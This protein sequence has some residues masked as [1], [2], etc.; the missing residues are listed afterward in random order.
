MNVRRGFHKAAL[1][2]VLLAVAV[3][4][5]G[6]RNEKTAP[7]IEQRTLASEDTSRRRGREDAEAGAGHPEQAG[8]EVRSASEKRARAMPAPEPCP[9]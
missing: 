3:A 5:S 7:S 2:A 1:S 9:L 6:G 4:L 8:R